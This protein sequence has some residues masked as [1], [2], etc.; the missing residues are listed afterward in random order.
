MKTALTSSRTPFKLRVD[1]PSIMAAKN[2]QPHSYSWVIIL[3]FESNTEHIGFQI[4]LENPSMSGAP[5]DPGRHG[6]LAP[7][8]HFSTRIGSGTFQ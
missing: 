8:N 4:S 2:R 1:S 5:Q 6:P 3:E 7:D